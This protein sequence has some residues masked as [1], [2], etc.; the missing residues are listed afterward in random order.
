MTFPCF[1][2]NS[3]YTQQIMVRN[4]QIIQTYGLVSIP[5]LGTNATYLKPF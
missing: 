5:C 3:A 4:I 1:D 2:K